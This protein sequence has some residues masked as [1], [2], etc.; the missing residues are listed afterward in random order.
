MTCTSLLVARRESLFFE[1][2][3]PPPAKIPSKGTGSGKITVCKGSPCRLTEKDEARNHAK[4]LRV[5]KI[6]LGKVNAQETKVTSCPRR[7]IVPS[8]FSSLKKPRP[9]SSRTCL[10]GLLP[11][12]CPFLFLGHPGLFC[13]LHLKKPPLPTSSPHALR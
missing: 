13:L 9:L 8:S 7:F 2:P 3:G 11:S 1:R 4:W 10:P 6:N 12:F 5:L